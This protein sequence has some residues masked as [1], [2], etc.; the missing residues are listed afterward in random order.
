MDEFQ[1]PWVLQWLSP[2]TVIFLYLILKWNI[3][4][5]MNHGPPNLRQQ[6]TKPRHV[7]NW[8]PITT[9]QKLNNMQQHQQNV[10]TTYTVS[11]PK[12]DPQVDEITLSPSDTVNMDI[13]LIN[14]W[15]HTMP[16]L[17]YITNYVTKNLSY[18]VGNL[19]ND[20]WKM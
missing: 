9:K 10:H 3:I 17:F 12:H 20:M 15:P 8:V 4:S 2:S 13:I 6:E 5:P 18:A 19:V 16:I 1:G 11:N 7:A 14:S